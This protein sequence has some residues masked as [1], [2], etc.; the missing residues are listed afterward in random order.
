[1]LTTGATERR[2]ALNKQL[3]LRDFL[4]SP[5]G[6]KWRLIKKK[7]S[8]AKKVIVEVSPTRPTSDGQRVNVGSFS[9]KLSEK[10]ALDPSTARVRARQLGR[11]RHEGSLAGRAALV[12][13]W[14]Y[15]HVERLQ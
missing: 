3:S 6:T 8:G 1:M 15:R 10:E 4:D 5:E 7:D 13:R 12:P 9:F 11:A 2:A 14:L